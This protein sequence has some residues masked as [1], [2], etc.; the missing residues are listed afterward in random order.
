MCQCRRLTRFALNNITGIAF[1]QALLT[2]CCIREL[3]SI[4]P[5]HDNLVLENGTR[6]VVEK[7]NSSFPSRI[8]RGNLTCLSI[9]DA[10]TQIHVA[11]NACFHIS[12][13]RLLLDNRC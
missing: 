6:R 8:Y 1:V 11:P 12:S 10:A 3:T 2:N 4:E 13:E 9:M 5:A 7:E